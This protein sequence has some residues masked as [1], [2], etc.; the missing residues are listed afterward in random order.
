MSQNV[1]VIALGIEQGA[2]LANLLERAK[3]SLAQRVVQ[4][5]ARHYAGG[6]WPEGRALYQ[7]LGVYEDHLL[8][9]VRHAQAT[10]ANASESRDKAA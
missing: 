6:H 9:L 2:E 4:V 3:A 1:V 10:V 5:E 7:A 8:S